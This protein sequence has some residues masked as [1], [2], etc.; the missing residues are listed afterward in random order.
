MTEDPCNTNGKP[1]SEPIALTQG[2]HTAFLTEHFDEIEGRLE[3][4]G[5]PFYRPEV[6]EGSAPRLGSTKRNRQLWF[7][8]PDG[9]G[10]EIIEP[11]GTGL[12]SSK[13]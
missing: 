5:I 1:R 2:P 10:I 4:M 6:R 12:T 8:D 3:E 13:L 11:R 7:Y 9:N